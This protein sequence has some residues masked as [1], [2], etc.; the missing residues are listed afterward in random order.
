MVVAPSDDSARTID[1]N[2]YN[3]DDSTTDDGPQLYAIGAEVMLTANLWTEAGLVNGSCGVVDDILKPD[4]DRTARVVMVNFPGYRGP[5]LSP[6]RPN[7]IPIT[8]IR[9]T[10]RNGLPLTLAW[11][12]TI[13][14]SQGMTLDRVTVDLGRSEFA[15]GLTFVA[16]SR[17]KTFNGL[18]VEPFDF[19]RFQRIQ[20]GR[21]V[22]A[23]RDEFDRLRRLAHSNAQHD[24]ADSSLPLTSSQR[25]LPP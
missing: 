11:A 14:K 9:A 6:S 25:A 5:S 19:S 4:D 8:Q 1:P 16:L 13:H 15:S 10:N 23:R 3:D 18:R 21:H 24:R 17:A 12:I 20:H 7:V 2:E 22:D